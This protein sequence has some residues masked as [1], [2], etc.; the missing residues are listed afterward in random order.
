[1]PQ[2]PA[3]EMAKS[4]FAT[5]SVRPSGVATTPPAIIVTETLTGS[6]L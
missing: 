1:M 3:D 6:E 5:P 4:A 2:L